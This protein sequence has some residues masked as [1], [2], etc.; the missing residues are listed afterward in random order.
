MSETKQEPNTVIPVVVLF[1]IFLFNDQN[2]SLNG[3]S[4]YQTFTFKNIIT[5]ISSVELQ[6]QFTSVLK[7]S[8]HVFIL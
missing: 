5:Q 1:S 3:L 4:T 7:K 6:L 2:D 8:L